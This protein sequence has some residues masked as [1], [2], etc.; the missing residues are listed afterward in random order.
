MYWRSGLIFVDAAARPVDHSDTSEYFALGRRA[1]RWRSRFEVIRGGGSV[2]HNDGGGKERRV[3]A[4]LPFVIACLWALILPVSDCGSDSPTA[5]T[6][7]L[8]SDS[9]AQPVKDYVI[10]PLDKLNIHVFE[11][12][13]LSMNDAQVDASGQLVLPLIGPVIAS[14]KTT[15]QLSKEIADRLQERYLQSPQVTVS[16]EESSGQTVTMEGEVKTPGV[17]KMAGRTTLMQAV[18]MAQGPSDKA[19]LRELMVIRIVNGT[20]KA[21]ICDYA[22]I[23]KGSAPDPILQGGDIVVMNGSTTKTLWTQ[24]L[25]AVPL[26][27]LFAAAS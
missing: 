18:A 9:G 13:D 1:Q 12:Q 24:L 21:A 11:V 2:M 14:G 19:D 7:A 26:A 27:A 6:L 16:V 10:G 22:Q 23:S 5:P 8:E 17:Y 25:Q 15:A 20:R 4:R 3:R